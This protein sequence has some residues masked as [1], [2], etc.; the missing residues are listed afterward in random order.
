MNETRDSFKTMYEHLII[1]IGAVRQA[2][3]D[4]MISESDYE[5]ITGEAY[6]QSD[7]N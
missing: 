2:V 4:N 1:A 3:M 6:E 7:T 5:Y